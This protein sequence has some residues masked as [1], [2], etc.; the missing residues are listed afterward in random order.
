MRAQ[1]TMSP[2]GVIKPKTIKNN[3]GRERGHKFGKV[4]RHRLWMAP[5]SKVRSS[6][7]LKMKCR[8]H[9]SMSNFGTN[10]SA[11]IVIEKI[12]SF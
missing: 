4:G 1:E 10:W 3:K 11:R 5:N 7:P 2:L 9:L 8:L 6:E 12:L